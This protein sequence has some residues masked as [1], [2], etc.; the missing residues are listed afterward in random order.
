[1]PD[2]TAALETPLVEVRVETVTTGKKTE[3]VGE[4]QR[5]DSGGPGKDTTEDEVGETASHT[6]YETD[7]D[8]SGEW[9]Y[10][11]AI[12]VQ[13][14]RLRDGGNHLPLVLPCWRFG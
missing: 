3:S 2:E 1:M 9:V 12:A 10:E 7:S 5:H 6:E 13:D 4:P 8:T 11:D 14:E